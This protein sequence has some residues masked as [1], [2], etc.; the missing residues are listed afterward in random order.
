MLTPRQR[1]SFFE[2]G[3][4]ALEGLFS[5]GEIAPLRRAFER[6]QHRAT[7]LNGSGEIRQSKFVVDGDAEQGLRIHRVVGCGAVEP[8]LARIAADQRLLAPVGELLESSH[9]VQLL[10][11]AHFKL[12]G[13]EVAF[14]WHQDSVH[15]R[16]GT[17]L[18]RD[19]NGTGSYV[20]TVLAIDDITEENGPLRFACGS[21]ARGHREPNGGSLP[22]DLARQC[23]VE[24]PTMR[25]GGVLLFGP[26]VYHASEPNRSPQPRRVLINGYASPGA[27][28]RHYPWLGSGKLMA[29]PA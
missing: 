26:Y 3:Y 11:Q 17:E 7:E 24:A 20:Q 10:N 14:G 16:Y 18:W 4:L 8:E 25:A 12:P 13:D 21:G 19:V 23:R 28:R 27:N 9:V 15:R 1:A 29:V 2:E 6:L 22:D 5:E